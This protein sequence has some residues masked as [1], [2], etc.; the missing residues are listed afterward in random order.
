MAVTVLTVQNIA[1]AGIVPSYVAITDL[2]DGVSFVNDGRTYLEVVKGGTG[3]V[4]ITVNSVEPCSQGFDHDTVV[5]VAQGVT[6]RIGPFP[7]SRFNNTSGNVTAL[8]D[9]VTDVTI[10]AFRLP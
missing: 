3:A 2:A 8:T 6:K 5:S 9:T 10:G 1:Q 4:E 7:V